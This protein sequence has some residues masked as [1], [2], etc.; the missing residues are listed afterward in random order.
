MCVLPLFCGPALGWGRE[1]TSN[2]RA[3]NNRYWVEWYSSLWNYIGQC[4]PTL[5]LHKTSPAHPMK[6]KAQRS[7]RLSKRWECAACLKFHFD[8]LTSLH[9]TLYIDTDEWTGQG[10][11]TRRP[12][13]QGSIHV[14]NSNAMESQQ[15]CFGRH[16]RGDSKNSCRG[17]QRHQTSRVDPGPEQNVVTSVNAGSLQVC[18]ACKNVL[19]ILICG[20][21]WRY[22]FQT[23]LAT[24]P[25]CV[26]FSR[27]TQNYNTI[28]IIV[29]SRC[30]HK[31]TWR[32]DIDSG[33]I[34]RTGVIRSTNS[35]KVI[36]SS[37][38]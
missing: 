9:P 12:D 15:R 37:Y 32:Q 17:C 31:N 30:Q 3:S 35:K 25:G 11:W 34:H 23:L 14:I 1:Q 13:Y 21:Q 20:W 10:V 26:R 22:S 16:S 6:P 36:V 8:I 29:A 27:R 4:R 33:C 2:R 7:R 18:S 24:A 28:S 19:S 38:S 5:R